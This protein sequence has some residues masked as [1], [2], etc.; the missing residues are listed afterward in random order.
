M[1]TLLLGAWLQGPAVW[2]SAPDGPSRP[3]PAAAA[4]TL[5]RLNSHLA[6]RSSVMSSP[7]GVTLQRARHYA[8]G[9]PMTLLSLRTGRLAVDLAPLAG[10]SM[11]RFTTD[12][13]DLLRP[14]AT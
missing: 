7:S 11:A 8:R 10:G 2:P 1:S 4:R 5:R 13:I 6:M 3:R 9:Q 14:M 12:G